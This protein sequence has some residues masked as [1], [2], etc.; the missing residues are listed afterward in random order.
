MCAFEQRSSAA[1]SATVRTTLPVSGAGFIMTASLACFHEGGGVRA[2]S[3]L[4][5]AGASWRNAREP[6]LR[7]RVQDEEQRNT[8]RNQRCGGERVE[9]APE[10]LE[11]RLKGFVVD[12]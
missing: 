10:R 7:R 12:H 3:A 2:A 9:N 5:P 1:T 8:E 11:V 4:A 6:G